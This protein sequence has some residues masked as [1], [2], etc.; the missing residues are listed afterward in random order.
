M[1]EKDEH[2]EIQG[3]IE[4][5]TLKKKKTSTDEKQGGQ[6]QATI[7]YHLKNCV[8]FFIKRE[9]YR[10][11]KVKTRRSDQIFLLNFLPKS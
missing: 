11:L 10:K 4:T 9:N 7:L 1:K 8:R 2:H 5:S 3:E 6:K